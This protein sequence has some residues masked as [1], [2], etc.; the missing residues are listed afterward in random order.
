MRAN[1]IRRVP[2]GEMEKVRFQLRYLNDPAHV[3]GLSANDLEWAEKITQACEDQG[4]VSKKQA[5]I[6][7]NLW[8]KAE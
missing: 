7:E 1:A 6:I 3:E 8:D 5:K 2:E 4:W